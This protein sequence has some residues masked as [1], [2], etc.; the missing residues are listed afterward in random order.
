MASQR[1]AGGPPA[2]QLHARSAQS[3]ER[4]IY[5]DM[6][7]HVARSARP[8]Q[9]GAR[10]GASLTRF[11][12][13][14]A[15]QGSNILTSHGIVAG[16]RFFRSGVAPGP[17]TR[18]VLPTP[19]SAWATVSCGASDA[20]SIGNE[21][22]QG[23]PWTTRGAHSIFFR[24]RSSHRRE[25]GQGLTYFSVFIKAISAPFTRKDY[26]ALLDDRAWAS[27]RAA[28]RRSWWSAPSSTR[29]TS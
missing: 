18:P 9:P 2:L 29:S 24:A 5:A 27:H 1:A 16:F 25:L 11:S 10:P 8:H 23:A 17:V 12:T 7:A 21:L 22:S 4:C 15:A 19:R 3:A 14:S 28:R 6:I 13:L 26:A 20:Y